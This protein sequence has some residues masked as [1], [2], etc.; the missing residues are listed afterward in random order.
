MSRS[1]LFI[2]VNTL[3]LVASAKQW[4]RATCPYTEDK[5][6]INS[7]NFDFHCPGGDPS[8]ADY[9]LYGYLGSFNPDYN[10]VSMLIAGAIPIAVE[11]VNRYVPNLK[12]S[13]N[14][15]WL[16]YN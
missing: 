6:P 5:R 4:T 11:E 14:S 13:P 3:C 9:F 7:S 8:I 10:G 15:D 12:N 1:S 16:T 2:L